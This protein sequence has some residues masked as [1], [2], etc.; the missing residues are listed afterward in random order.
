M[1]DAGHDVEFLMCDDILQSSD[2]DGATRKLQDSVE[3]L[4]V[5]TH[6]DFAGTGYDVYLHA[7][8]GGLV[9]PALVILTL[10]SRSSIHAN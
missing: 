3:L 4:Y 8:I 5:M 6:G 2:L 7:A 9:L 1:R 10:P